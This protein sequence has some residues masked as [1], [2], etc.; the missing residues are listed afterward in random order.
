MSTCELL[1]QWGIDMKPNSICRYSTKHT[2]LSS[3][4]KVTWSRYDM[5]EILLTCWIFLTRFKCFLLFGKTM[6][7]K[8]HT[9]RTVP[10]SNWN[11]TKKIH[12]RL[13][14]WFL[15]HPVCEI[16]RACVRFQEL[17]ILRK[18]LGSSFYGR[19]RVVQLFSFLC[20]LFVLFVFVLCYV[21]YIGLSIRDWPFGFL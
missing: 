18:H 15:I 6:K 8:Y 9:V 11:I 20:Y 17:F 16:V 5:V 19:P 10:I 7:T 1:S 13:L 3:L 4:E 2:L 12:D 21:P 14:F